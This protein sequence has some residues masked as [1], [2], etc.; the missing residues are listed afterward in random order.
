MNQTLPRAE[1]IYKQFMN[2]K[3]NTHYLKMIKTKGQIWGTLLN[4]FTF[5]LTFSKNSHELCS[6]QIFRRCNCPYIWEE[7][8]VHE[9]MKF[10]L[11]IFQSHK[12]DILKIS[13]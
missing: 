8:L 7:G 3:I 2:Q 11:I 10:L 9:S 13:D 4:S 6:S 1:C 5:R 12:G